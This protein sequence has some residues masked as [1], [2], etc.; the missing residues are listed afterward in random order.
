VK[1]KVKDWQESE[2]E[3]VKEWSEWAAPRQSHI[4]SLE[5]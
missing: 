3:T 4:T 1:K 5:Q 2:K